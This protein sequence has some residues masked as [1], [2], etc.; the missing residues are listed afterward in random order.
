MYLIRH[1]W[2]W[3]NKFT[4]DG[5][6]D[7]LPE[8]GRYHIYGQH[9]C[10]FFHRTAI[11]RVLKGLED[12]ISMDNLDYVNEKDKGWK[13]SPEVQVCFMLGVEKTLTF[14]VGD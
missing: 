2:Y 8:K 11:G 10:P 12:V 5:S 14:W 6:T 7:F 1:I 3:K 9:V 13:F 4:A